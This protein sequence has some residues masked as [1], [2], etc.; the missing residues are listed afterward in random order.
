MSDATKEK[1]TLPLFR[2]IVEHLKNQ[3]H[4]GILSVHEA[5]PTE[6]LV[7]EQHGVSRMTAR[8]ALE[9]IEAE[10]L[11]YSEDRRGRFVSPNGLITK[12]T[13]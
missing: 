2:Q 12:S 7:A 8:R 10:G 1:T 9:A 6:R 4:T 13:Q 5:L 11:A 3:I